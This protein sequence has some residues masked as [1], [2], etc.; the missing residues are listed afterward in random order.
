[1]WGSW[2]PAAGLW[3]LVSGIGFSSE[4]QYFPSRHH[5]HSLEITL[6]DPW[7]GHTDPPGEAIEKGHLTICNCKSAPS[8]GPGTKI[9][10]A[11]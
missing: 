11:M 7:K 4:P 3:V 10:N 1:M 2:H 8:S 9:K 6:T 5:L